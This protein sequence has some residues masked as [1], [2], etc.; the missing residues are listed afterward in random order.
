MTA[1][2]ILDNLGRFSHVNIDFFER[3]STVRKF[4]KSEV[5]LHEGEICKSFYYVLSGSFCQYQ[6]TEMSDDI[7]D[8][9]LPGEWVFN[10]PSLTEQIASSTTIK[11]FT[12]SEVIEL[13]L[14]SCH[15][16]LSKM[17]HLIHGLR[18]GQLWSKSGKKDGIA[19]SMLL[20]V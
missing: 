11:A 10:Q 4:E 17:Q 15:F 7:I 5:L 13:S 3:H 12:K 2:E 9:H 19:Y 6:S 14:E 16:L 18:T 1:R 20:T 8:L